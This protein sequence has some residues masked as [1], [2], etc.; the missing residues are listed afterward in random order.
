MFICAVSRKFAQAGNSMARICSSWGAPI[1]KQH[2][3]HIFAAVRLVPTRVA[4][5]ERATS[6]PFPKFVIHAGTL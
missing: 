5:G 2:W 1:E 3:N 4:A 6:D